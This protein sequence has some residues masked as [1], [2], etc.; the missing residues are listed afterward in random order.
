MLFSTWSH[1]Q[2]T[3]KRICIDGAKIF[4]QK[5]GPL[6]RT[7]WQTT[8]VFSVKLPAVDVVCVPPFA[9]HRVTHSCYTYF[10]WFLRDQD[11]AGMPEEQVFPLGHPL[12]S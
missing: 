9:E 2:G 4:L 12:L 7:L 5:S 11:T 8:L 3:R 10:S 6:S 1:R